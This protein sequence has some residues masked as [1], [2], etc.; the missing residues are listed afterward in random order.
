MATP[1]KRNVFTLEDRVFVI[2]RQEKDGESSRQNAANVGVGKTQIQNIL[3]NKREIMK[4]WNE[5]IG[6]ERKYMKK[7]KYQYGDINDIVWE[8]F[9]IG[10][11]KNI[12]IIGKLIQEK[13]L[14]LSLESGHDDFTGNIHFIPT[15]NFKMTVFCICG[16][17]H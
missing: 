10:R 14:V 7:R 9:N 17:Q 12:P 6:T 16:K 3:L 2:N 4:Q 15:F 1:R 11:S 13:A 5:N 8:W